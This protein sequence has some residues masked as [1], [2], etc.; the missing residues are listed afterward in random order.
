MASLGSVQVRG[1]WVTPLLGDHLQ[2]M[3]DLYSPFFVPFL[4]GVDNLEIVILKTVDMIYFHEVFETCRCIR[5]APQVRLNEGK[6]VG[7]VCLS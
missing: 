4:F 6:G 1:L 5:A 7:K 2:G 3:R